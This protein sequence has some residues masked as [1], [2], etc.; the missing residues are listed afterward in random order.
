MYSLIDEMIVLTLMVT[1]NLLPSGSTLSSCDDALFSACHA[2]MVWYVRKHMVCVERKVNAVV[3]TPRR[4]VM[5]TTTALYV[6]LEETTTQSSQRHDNLAP[7]SPS[8]RVNSV[9]I[10]I[11]PNSYTV[12]LE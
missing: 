1:R 5:T 10:N 4:S 2:H 8:L 9:N 6:L 11:P 3:N 7:P 12:P